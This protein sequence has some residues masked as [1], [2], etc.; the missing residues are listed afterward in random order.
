[1][2]REAFAQGLS[3]E[4][5]CPLKATGGKARKV[6]GSKTSS[7]SDSRNPRKGTLTLFPK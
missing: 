2:P 4:G 7:N 3:P 6:P 5:K 1:M